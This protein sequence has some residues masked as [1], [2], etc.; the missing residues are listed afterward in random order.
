[1]AALAASL[2]LY[3]VQ[4]HISEIPLECSYEDVSAALRHLC[5]SSKASGSQGHES[6]ASEYEGSNQSADLQLV[7]SM[8]EASLEALKG[9]SESSA[10]SQTEEYVGD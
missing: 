6:I 9:K 5:S 2:P 10:I 3:E 4:V 1:M 8:D 7:K